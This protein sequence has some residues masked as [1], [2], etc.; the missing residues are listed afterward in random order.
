[1]QPGTD[2]QCQ[3]AVPQESDPGVFTK[4]IKVFGCR[5]AQ[6]GEIRSLEPANFEK[7]EPLHGLT[8]LFKW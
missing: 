1:M 3:E 4:L 7:L 6:V 2:G 8:F 5:G